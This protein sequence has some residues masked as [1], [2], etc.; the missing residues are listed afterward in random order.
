M[1][2]LLIQSITCNTSCRNSY[3]VASSAKNNQRQDFPAASVAGST[4]PPTFCALRAP[5]G[6]RA[7]LTLNIRRKNPM[8][9]TIVSGTPTPS[10]AVTFGLL[11]GL[12]AFCLAL[13]APPIDTTAMSASRIAKP[14]L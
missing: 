7:I 12:V 11:G 4:L 1:L 9:L 2:P 14:P 10:R 5:L 13:Q 6:I 8:V 3:Q